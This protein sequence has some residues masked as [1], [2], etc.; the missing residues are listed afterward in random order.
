MKTKEIFEA[1]KKAIFLLDLTVPGGADGQ[2]KISIRGTGF[3]VESD[4]TFITNAHVYKEVPEGERQF[5]GARIWADPDNNGIVNYQRREIE[6]IKLDEENDIA[7]MKLVP[8]G[9]EKFTTISGLGEDSKVTEGE[10]VVFI[11]FPLALELIMMQMGVTLSVNRAIVSTVKKRTADGSL[12]FFMID[13]H[14]NNGSSG[15]PLF[16]VDS[17]KVIGIASGKIST[18]VKSPEGK[19]FDIPANMGI[20]RPISYVKKIIHKN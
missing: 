11:G 4:G 14:I 15:S 2:Q 5:L 17:G 9:D 1:N 10:D 7:L 13:T 3:V 8:V 19:V 20:C 18:K 12:H 6:L 16:H